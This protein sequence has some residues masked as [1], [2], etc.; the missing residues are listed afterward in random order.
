MN[1]LGVS[2]FTAS[3]IVEVVSVAVC[4]LSRF[5]TH[6]TLKKLDY[7]VA[8]NSRNMNEISRN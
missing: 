2:S 5:R 7:K 4:T 3:Y 6:L 1:K 8:V